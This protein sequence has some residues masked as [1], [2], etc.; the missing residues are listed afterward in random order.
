MPRYKV[1]EGAL[2]II[3]TKFS[4]IWC[5]LFKELRRMKWFLKM[6]QLS[7]QLKS[8]GSNVAVRNAAVHSLLTSEDSP[9]VLAS[10]EEV[11][12]QVKA[13]MPTMASPTSLGAA[14]L[15]AGKQEELGA[16]E[17]EKFLKEHELEHLRETAGIKWRAKKL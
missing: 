15:E 13:P 17:L 10:C 14:A 4:K 11:S 8:K 7:Q 2:Y 12:S 6:A 5:P 1:G 3:C 16:G 9:E